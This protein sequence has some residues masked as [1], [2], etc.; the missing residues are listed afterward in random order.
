LIVYST[1]NL[2]FIIFQCFPW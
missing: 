1:E 2:T